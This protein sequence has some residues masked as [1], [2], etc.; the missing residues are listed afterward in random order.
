MVQG[1]TAVPDRDGDAARV[2][3]ETDAMTFDVLETCSWALVGATFGVWL[4]LLLSC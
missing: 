3:Q 2:S 4:G 1:S